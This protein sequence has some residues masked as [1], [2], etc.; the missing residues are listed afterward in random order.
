MEELWQLIDDEF[1]VCAINILNSKLDEISDM[2]SENMDGGAYEKL[3]DELATRLVDTSKE[4]FIQGFL[5]GIAV[6]KTGLHEDYVDGES[7]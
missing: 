5:R 4:F 2:V 3:E 1:S 6:V 7:I